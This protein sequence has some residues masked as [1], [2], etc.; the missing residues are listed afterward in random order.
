M[1]PKADDPSVLIVQDGTYYAAARVRQNEI[2]L[3]SLWD[4]DDPS[5]FVDQI[6]KD[7]DGQ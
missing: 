6:L 2:V 1:M 3:I 5:G 4:V 7:L